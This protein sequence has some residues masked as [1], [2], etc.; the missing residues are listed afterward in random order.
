VYPDCR[1]VGPE[2]P[3]VWACVCLLQQLCACP[4]LSLVSDLFPAQTTRSAGI[5][6]VTQRT[7]SFISCRECF[8]GYSYTQ[9]TSIRRDLVREVCC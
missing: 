6:S 3:A 5:T 7:K 2:D 8:E 1:V 4:P 9:G